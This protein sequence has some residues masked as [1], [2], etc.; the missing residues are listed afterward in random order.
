MRMPLERERKYFNILHC[1]CLRTNNILAGKTVIFPL[2]NIA[3]GKYQF[4]PFCL[5][6][7][8]YLGKVGY[9]APLEFRS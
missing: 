4:F 3:K 5:I 9:G 2:S 7:H 6:L 1:S 8:L